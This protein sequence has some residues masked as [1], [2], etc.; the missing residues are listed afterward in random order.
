MVTDAPD[1]ETAPVQPR[2]TSLNESDFRAADIAAG[3]TSV[4]EAAQAVAP[5][6]GTPAT[7][8]VTANARRASGRRALDYSLIRPPSYE[9]IVGGE[10]PSPF[11]S[12]ILLIGL[13]AL[14]GA[15]LAS[16]IGLGGPEWWIF[17]F[18]FTVIATTLAGFI[19][20]SA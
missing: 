20:R 6:A 18:L 9:N 13:F 8:R 17:G 19:S 14:L 3:P 11:V 2:T 1:T 4:T 10:A 15:A 7:P 12:L 16:G 5:G